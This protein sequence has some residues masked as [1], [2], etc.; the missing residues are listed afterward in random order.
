MALITDYAATVTAVVGAITA[1]VT[2]LWKLFDAL[3]PLKD[4]GAIKA[5]VSE[6]PAMKVQLQELP[7]LKEKIER[8]QA[9][10]DPLALQVHVLWD[11]EGLQRPRSDHPSVQSVEQSEPHRVG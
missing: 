1:V 6:L 10:L 2:V 11:R 7:V 8:I 3:R 9:V 4:I 5:S